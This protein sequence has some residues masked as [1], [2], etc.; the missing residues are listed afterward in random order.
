MKG[1]HIRSLLSYLLI[2]I[3]VIG[4]FVWASLSDYNSDDY[5]YLHYFPSPEEAVTDLG[6]NYDFAFCM[7]P[8][9]ET[10]PQVLKSIKNHYLYWNNGRLANALMFFS[11]LLPKWVTD[12]AHSIALLMMIWTMCRLALGPGWM[13]K[14]LIVASILL[15]VWLVWPWYD[16]KNS[17][18]YFFNYIWSV[19][20]TC[21][22]LI[23]F[24]S[25]VRPATA[26]RVV[27]TCIIGF[28]GAM[29]HEGIS[30]PIACGLL[31]YLMFPL[32]RRFTGKIINP[33]RQQFIAAG[34]FMTGL[35]IIMVSPALWSRIDELQTP[36][37]WWVHIFIQYGIRLYYLYIG[38]ALFGLLTLRRGL[39]WAWRAITGN[40][41]LVATVAASFCLVAYTGLDAMRTSW[42]LCVFCTILIAKGLNIFPVFK[43][44]RKLTVISSVISAILLSGF[45]VDLCATQIRRT[46]ELRHIYSTLQKNP[47]QRVFYIDIDH[48]DEDYWWRYKYA[49]RFPAQEY[50]AD[51][52]MLDHIS[53][54]KYHHY[55]VLPEK[56]RGV[57]LDSLPLV[58]GTAGLRGEYPY[59]YLPS[60]KFTAGH[61]LF[62]TTFRFEEGVSPFV[63]YTP[64]SP[65]RLVWNPKGNYNEVS[66]AYYY[67]T[68][69]LPVTP[70]M[71]ALHVAPADADTVYMLKIVTGRQTLNGMRPVKI[72]KK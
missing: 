60:G 53:E 11:I 49:L 5:W 14:T 37:F 45:W 2:A 8:E 20:L 4:F 59:Y 18:D 64:S 42:A 54:G 27:W 50:L 26:G 12:V 19:A 69:S 31:A 68:I 48:D 52:Q 16:M 22:F 55:V 35:I 62:N 30:M 23:L 70:E 3:S 71:R 10:V 65:G 34:S 41:I 33:T 13:K 63:K 28:L 46:A 36:G 6:P 51:F 47:G 24:N 57:P 66:T 67:L 25:L 17:V 72:D 44:Y 56:F 39:G 58:P 40:L 43:E 1:K 21:Y 29:M 7:Q 9:I 38:L 32:L 61:V 15:I